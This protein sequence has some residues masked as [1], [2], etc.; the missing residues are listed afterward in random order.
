M[1]QRD[2]PELAGVPLS[3]LRVLDLGQGLAGALLGVF[4]ADYGAEVI[5]VEPPWGDPLRRHPAAPLWLRGRKSLVLDLREAAGRRQAQEL[6]AACDVLVESFRPGVAE[7]LGLGYDELSAANPGLVHTSISGFGRRGPHARRKGYEG[8]VLAKL[9]GLGHVG[10]LAGRPGPAFPAVP[11]ASFSAAQTALQGTLLALYVRERSGRGQRVESSLVQGMAAHDPWDWF[12][13]LVAERYPKAFSTAPPYSGRGVPSASFAFRLLVCLTKDGHWLQFSQV[14]P[15][16]FREFMEVLGLAWMYD[17]PRWRSAP[18]FESEEERERF[19]E[20]LLEAAGRRTA[21]EWEEVFQRHPNV[22]AERFRTP[23]EALDHPQMRHNGHVLEDQDPRRGRTLELAPLVRIRSAPGPGPRPAP[24]PAPGEHGAELLAELRAGRL[25]T[26]QP[27]RREALPPEP[28]AGVTVLELGLWYA[29]PYGPAILA[30]YGARVIKLEPL[31]GDPIRSVL[32]FPDAGGVKMLQGKES[33]AVDLEAPA[34][35]EIA[36]RLARRADLALMSYRAGVAERLGLDA[37]RLRRENPRL[38]YLWAPGYGS[39]G[40]CGR[41]PAFAPTIGA[42]SGAARLQAGPGIPQGPGIP[43]EKLKPASI[44]LG[45]A[46]QAPGN[47]DGCG[48]LGVATAL[49]LGLLA[50]ER[51]GA[52]PEL[53]TSMLGTTAWA[54]SEDGIDYPGRPPRPGPDPELFGLSA[55]YRLY[56]AAEGWIFLAAPQPREWEGLCRGLADLVDLAGDPRFATPEARARH[57]SELARLL[58]GVFERRP[59]SEWERALEAY[60]VACAEVEK[61]PV[62]RA[63][64]DDPITREAGFLS[65]V[66]HPS[67]G[68]HRRLAPL[69]E[70]SLTPGRA[71]PAP[72]LGQHTEAVLLEL[73]YG[74]EEV[75][76]LEAAGVIGR[77]GAQGSPQ[78]SSAP[79]PSS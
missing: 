12:L 65:E 53:L 49:L 72:L 64:M 32:P 57:D 15:H 19:W 39:D 36:L 22:W 46:A 71:R 52:A 1:A 48:A 31:S 44:R 11:W 13:R 73:G 3:G 7:R 79:R 47:A 35:R 27:A 78:G 68:R 18:E 25:R 17:D 42:A 38:V 54:L 30:D 9:G 10:G 33:V 24:A 58:A 2:A 62:A 29:A 76:A 77:A 60:D 66:E 50:R 75:A 20:L 59:A 4:L 67:F 16:L 37:A 61:G 40:P 34:G 43:L 69:A 28:L 51:T 56:P 5:R 8:I 45:F 41:K 6:A 74:A 70:L 14:S 26:A 55:L 21:A 63:V 23:R